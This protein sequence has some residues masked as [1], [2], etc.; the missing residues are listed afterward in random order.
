MALSDQ[1][2]AFHEVD[3]F[4]HLILGLVPLGE[5]LDTLVDR[6]APPHGGLDPAPDDPALFATLGALALRGRL[7]DLVDQ[8]VAAG[9]PPA[10]TEPQPA[11]DDLL[12]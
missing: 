7:A 4:L 10:P 2:P 11:L 8:V 6:L 12:R 5:R 3:P 9:A 1:K